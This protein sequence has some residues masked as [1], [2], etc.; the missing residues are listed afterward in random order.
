MAFSR[1]IL[2]PCARKGKIPWGVTL[3]RTTVPFFF[4]TGI[5]AQSTSSF[6][7]VMGMLKNHSDI[8][9]LEA[10]IEEVCSMPTIN[11]DS[12]V[13]HTAIFQVAQQYSN[14]PKLEVGRL[15]DK[16][17][18]HGVKHQSIKILKPLNNSKRNETIFDLHDHNRHSVLSG[19]RF[20]IHTIQVEERRN[21]L[22][23]IFGR[24]TKST[25]Q[26]ANIRTTAEEYLRYELSIDFRHLAKGGALHLDRYSVYKKDR[27]H[28][29]FLGVTAQ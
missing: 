29:Y 8:D 21:N 27:K 28:D 24:G 7:K 2:S 9:T 16:V 26:K 20:A 15:C 23:L 11:F 17:Y 3:R 18:A 6:G 12:K 13:V 25:N 5:C 1:H 22:I 4:T 14:F 19:I 10:S